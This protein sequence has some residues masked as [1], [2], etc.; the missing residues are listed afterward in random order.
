MT[1][2]A[3]II[4]LKTA[5]WLVGLVPLADGLRRG[6][7]GSMGA[8]EHMVAEFGTWGLRLLV[9][10]LAAGP[11]A[12]ALKSRTL[13]SLR[14]E[15]GLLA[16]LYAA[17][18]VAAYVIFSGAWRWPVEALLERP[19][20]VP[21]TLALL[22]LVPAAVA[23]FAAVRRRMGEARWRRVQGW[24]LAAA[25]LTVLHYL[26]PAWNEVVAPYVYGAGV[27]ALL[28]W[29]IKTARARWRPDGPG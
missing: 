12:R 22:V 3:F 17:A 5:V 20:F 7:G 29:R 4:C 6:V 23:S 16:F 13:L 26:M 19:D 11:L 14:R 18:H 24:A 27:A 1:S 25:P 8:Q 28:G 2:P 9:A 21:G 10:V 15:F